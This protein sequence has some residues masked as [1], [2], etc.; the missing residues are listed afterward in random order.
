MCGS[1][2]IAALVYNCQ[3]FLYNQVKDISCNQV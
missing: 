3:A 2:D 1:G